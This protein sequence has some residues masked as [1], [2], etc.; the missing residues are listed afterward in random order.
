MQAVIHTGG[1]PTWVEKLGPY[2]WGTLPLANRH[3]LEYWITTC[4]DMQIQDIWLILDDGAE[5]VESAIGNGD[6]FGVRIHYSF[7]HAEKSPSLFFVRNPESYQGGLLHVQLPGFPMRDEGY[8][9]EQAAPVSGCSFWREQGFISVFV[10]RDHAAVQR[11][12][13]NGCN[14]SADVRSE[15]VPWRPVRLDTLKSYYDISMDLVKGGLTRYPSPGYV[16]Q[17]GISFGYNVITPRSCLLNA[18][19]LIQNECRFGKLCAIGPNAVIGSH[20]VIDRGTKVI[21]SIVL[22]NTYLGANL[23]IEGKIV[24]GRKLADPERDVIASVDDEWLFAQVKSPLKLHDS[25]RFVQS[26]L[27]AVLIVCIQF[28][29][30]LILRALAGRMLKTV[31]RTVTGRKRKPFELKQF[32]PTALSK[33]TRLFLSLYLERFP[34]FWSVVTGRLWLCGQRPLAPGDTLYDDLPCYFPAA[35]T[36]AD[37]RDEDFPEMEQVDSMLY[38]TRRSVVEDLRLLLHSLVRRFLRGFSVLQEQ[39]GGAHG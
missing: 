5:W 32:E 34:V 23:D 2:T 1:S 14:I 20:T 38:V 19:L 33:R 26:W 35:L 25:L 37:E 21:N 13:E 6:R 30:F 31:S 4:V 11:Y 27:L 9:P 3:A 29:P 12:V 39:D 28:V 15:N 10:S 36:Y 24:A 8:M 16:E 22:D 17:E 18:P 7:L